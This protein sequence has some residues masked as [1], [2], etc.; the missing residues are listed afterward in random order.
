MLSKMGR[1][2]YIDI[3]GV[4]ATGRE[5]VVDD[6]VDVPSFGSYA[7]PSPARL[8]VRIRRVDRGL[9]VKGT[10]DVD[11][12]GSCDRCLEDVRRPLHLLVDERF[13][14]VADATDPLAEANVLHHDGLD[15]A[16]L[17]RQ[18][19]DAAL[20]MTLVCESTCPGL[21]QSCGTRHATGRSDCPP[22]DER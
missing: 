8:D 16:D 2:Q 11:Y 22:L 21:C 17:A 3:G 19:I 20:P 12:E 6:E 18:L 14:A 9:D 4:L 10:I 7:F 13:P 15:V 1:S 5:L